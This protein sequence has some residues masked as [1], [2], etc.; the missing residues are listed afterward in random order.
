VFSHKFAVATLIRKYGRHLSAT[1]V[2]TSI[3]PAKSKWQTWQS[4]IQR[5]SD[6]LLGKSG[7]G[8]HFRGAAGKTRTFNLLIRSFKTI[9]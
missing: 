4:E 1:L 8:R 6:A 2:A 7:N 5:I 3:Q 9:F